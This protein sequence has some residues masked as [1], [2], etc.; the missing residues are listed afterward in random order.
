MKRYIAIDLLALKEHKLTLEEWTLLENIYFMSNNEFGYC[1]ASKETLRDIIQV[2]N[3]QIYKIITRLTDN[4]FLVKN[5]Q[6]GFIKV[7]QKWLAISSGDTLQKMENESPKNGKDTLQKMETKK[8]NI[9]R[10]IK[11]EEKINKKENS[12]FD[13][14]EIVSDLETEY[15]DNAI[16]MKYPLNEKKYLDFIQ[17][18]KELKKPIT[19][20]AAK[21]HI[22][23]LCKYPV[24]IQEEMIKQSISSNWQGLFV[25]KIA[26]KQQSSF[27]Q[28]KSKV[29]K[30]N[31]FIDDFFERMAEQG[32]ESAIDVEVLS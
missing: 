25:L 6:T 11:K 27:T 5:K 7:T 4:G 19:K 22:Q 32:K 30:T 24:D 31:E 1:Y 13:L 2:S 16:E 3:G 12:S 29:Q 15:F 21:E 8:D 26:N 23:L 17:F 14:Q 10:D 18:R 28:P 20:T 9:K